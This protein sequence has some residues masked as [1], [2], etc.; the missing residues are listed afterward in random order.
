MTI[1]KNHQGAYNI[2]EI[3][4]GELLARQYFFPKNEAIKLF[5]ETVMHEF[6]KK[7]LGWQ[8]IA[9]TQ[10]KTAE[11]LEAKGIITIIRHPASTWQVKL[12]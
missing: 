12:K 2:S 10:R 5:R 9:H 3:V 1:E 7:Y 8:S 6:L 11:R 4:G